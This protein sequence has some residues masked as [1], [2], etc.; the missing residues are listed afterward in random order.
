MRKSI[1]NVFQ[2]PRVENWWKWIFR[3]DDTL[4]AVTVY[5]LSKRNSTSPRFFPLYDNTKN[6]R[7]ILFRGTRLPYVDLAS[8]LFLKKFC[9]I[10][11]KKLS[12]YNWVAIY[13]HKAILKLD[14]NVILHIDDPEYST[15]EI[16][17][18][19]EIIKIQNN[20]NNRTKVIVTNSDTLEYFRNIFEKI[21]I[22]VIPQGFNEN[23]FLSTRNKSSSQFSIAYSSPY[24]DYI[25]DKHEKHS[26][27]SAIH[28]VDVLIPLINDVDP[29]IEIRL[30]GRVGPNAK[31]KL[32]K[33]ENVRLF[34]MVD[35][36]ENMRLLADSS[37]GIYPR[38]F[39]H[40]RRVQKVFEYAGAGIPIVSYD[41]IDTKIVRE[42]DWG[43]LVE[44]PEEM[45]S[46]IV[47]LKQDESRLNYYRD[48]ILK[49]KSKYSW[50][51]LAKMYDAEVSDLEEGE[52]WAR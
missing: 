46:S 51:E 19:E 24:I 10:F 44:T 11:H 47:A 20:R 32:Q 52:K 3:S 22:S 48:N 42:E 40:R 16:E 21:E 45:V 31:R 34:G 5:F 39:D 17:K 8:L 4:E 29:T 13:D 30:I 15:V 41:L 18:I 14:T 23:V 9:R 36:K 2:N 33:F 12:K 38:T 43:V 28:L 35:F 25:G 49:T 7:I 37:V 26:A 6:F 1:N 27:W 50:V